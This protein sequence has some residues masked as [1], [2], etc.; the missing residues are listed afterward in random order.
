MWLRAAGANGVD[1]ERGPRIGNG[2]ML[3]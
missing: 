2:S 1:P 3:V